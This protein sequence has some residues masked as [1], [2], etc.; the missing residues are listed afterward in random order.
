MILSIRG[1]FSLIIGDIFS[2]RSNGDFLFN[3][4]R[5]IATFVEISLSNLAGGISEF[6]PFKV[7][8]IISSP[9]LLRSTIIDLILSRYNSKI[10]I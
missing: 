1:S 5:T 8:G 3:F 6:I 9:F 10:F 4:E 7:S 2:A